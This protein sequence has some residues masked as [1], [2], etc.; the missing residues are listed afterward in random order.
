MSDANSVSL[1]FA[2]E[3]SQGVV[4]NPLNM[5][6]VR[7]TG[8]SFSP[9][10]EFTDS[11]EVN[12]LL[13]ASNSVP[14]SIAL[15]GTPEFECSYSEQFHFFLP[16]A[17]YSVGDVASWGGGMYEAK[18]TGAAVDVVVVAG[19]PAV[20]KFKAATA[21][22]VFTKIT[23]G[24]WFRAS[25]MPEEVNNGIFKVL[26]KTVSGSDTLIT[27]STDVPLVADIGTDVTIEYS[28]I[29]N[30]QDA[31]GA[32]VNQKSTFCFEQG[33]PILGDSSAESIYFLLKGCQVSSF[34]LTLAPNALVTG[35]VGFIGTT[36]DYQTTS[37]INTYTPATNYPVMSAADARTV[38]HQDNTFHQV[39]NFGITIS[40]LAR[41]RNV[42]GSITNSG[43]GR[44][45]LKPELAISEYWSKRQSFLSSYDIKTGNTT[46]R[47]YSARMGDS[48][49]R[50]YVFTFPN[51]VLTGV[52]LPAGALDEDLTIEGTGKVFPYTDPVSSQVYAMQIDRFGAL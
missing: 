29:R 21:D 9:S 10:T 12:P 4:P 6:G 40:D 16:A 47:S 33:Y 41:A 8:G 11:G 34:E 48:E 5:Y 31:T 23:T 52:S 49:G 18:I 32:L 2:K 39:T 42:V 45:S 46:P 50:T 20:Y 15:E 44:N 35:N 24:Q 36:Y 26:A 3:V 19:P 22:N 7:Y 14:T 30:G 27:V 38:V 43:T 28:M 51:V 17:I 13:M 25:G 37:Y 1:S